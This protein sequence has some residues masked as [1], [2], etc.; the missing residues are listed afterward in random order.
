MDMD[1]QTATRTAI[2]LLNLLRAGADAEADY[3]AAVEALARTLDLDPR[4]VDA[5][6]READAGS[7]PGRLKPGSDLA[8]W[9]VEEFEAMA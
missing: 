3:Q 7:V 5:A 8:A 4:E 2:N 6:V 1:T 9:I